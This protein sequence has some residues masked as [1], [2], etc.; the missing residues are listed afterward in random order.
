MIKMFQ[1]VGIEGIYFNI[2]KVIYD[3]FIVNIIFN[4]EKLKVFFLKL[5]IRKGC[6]FLLLLFNIVL[7]VLVIVIRVEKE[8]NVI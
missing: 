2:I 1:K 8:I 3:K 7:E 5:G 6:L 4:G